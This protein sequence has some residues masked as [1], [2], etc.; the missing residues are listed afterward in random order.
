MDFGY[1]GADLEQYKLRFDAK[2]K[3]N[4]SDA[5]KYGPIEELVRLVNEVSA[6]QLVSGVGER[7]DLPAFMR[8]VAGAELRRA[9]TTGSSATPA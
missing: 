1:L 8:Y 3:E 6:D 4:K 9:S 2:T 7:L 5:E